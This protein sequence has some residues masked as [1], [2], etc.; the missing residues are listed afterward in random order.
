MGTA[1]AGRKSRNQR[2]KEGRSALYRF[3]ILLP[4]HIL[5]EGSS[6]EYRKKEADVTPVMY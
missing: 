5:R 1:H 3:D 2:Q 6:D 4:N